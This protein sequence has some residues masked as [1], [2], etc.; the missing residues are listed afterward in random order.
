[1]LISDDFPPKAPMVP[2][3][4]LLTLSFA[5]VSS[6]VGLSPVS[7]HRYASLCILMR[8]SSAEWVC[9]GRTEPGS[10]AL[11]REKSAGP[12]LSFRR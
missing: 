10:L 7:G 6:G 8:S 3:T 5:E 1:M 11:C 4:A 2:I 9:Q 12:S